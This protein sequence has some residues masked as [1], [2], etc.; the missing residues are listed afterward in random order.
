MATA[1]LA[2]PSLQP[3]T[4]AEMTCRQYIREAIADL[5]PDLTP[6]ELERLYW[7]VVDLAQ[8]FSVSP[9][10]PEVYL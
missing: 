2:P 4:V 9:L 1:R 7:R 10:P 8:N 3:S 5:R 6:E